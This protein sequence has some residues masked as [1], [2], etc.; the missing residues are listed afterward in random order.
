MA[1]SSWIEAMQEEIYQFERLNVWELV[2]K[3]LGKYVINMKWLWKSKHDEENIVIRNKARLVTKEYGQQ[4]GIDFEES[5][6]PVA[7]LKPIRLFVVYVA[8]KSFLSEE[9]V[10][11]F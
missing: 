3:P 9:F 5:F 7:R 2:D 10:T 6:A 4:E 11:T 1:D 8:H